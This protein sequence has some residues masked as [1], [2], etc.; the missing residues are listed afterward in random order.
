MDIFLAS[1]SRQQF[2]HRLRSK[3]TKNGKVI[4]FT[5]Y[6]YF[7]QKLDL[8]KLLDKFQEVVLVPRFIDENYLIQEAISPLFNK[9][10]D[11]HLVANPEYEERYRIIYEFAARNN[12]SIKIITVYDFC[13]R[14]LR[15]VYVPDS[16]YEENPRLG[17]M[18]PKGSFQQISKSIIDVSLASVLLAA[19][20]PLW[21]LSRIRITQQSPGPIFYK[22]K[23]VGLNY[24]EFECVKFRSMRLDAEAF[25]A[26]FSSKRDKR[27]FGYGAF[28]RATRID[29]LPQLLNIFRGD[30]S[31]VGPRPERKVFVES[32]EELIPHYATRHVVK[33]GI[34]GYAQV[35]YPYGTGAK[36]AR[37]KLMYDLYYIKNW[38]LSLELK[39]VW[40]TIITV[41][42]SGGF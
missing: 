6:D 10:S 16:V 41:L 5:G 15:K 39:I 23:R 24:E 13:E 12:K 27:V 11:I 35:M 38:S 14:E 17:Q 31:L 3:R 19:T 28:M 32:F 4:L 30:V 34:T 22:Q 2:I 18:R 8:R 42:S 26:Q 36:D 29:E 20:S 1:T 25:G 21:L 9:Y 37:H 7:L 33:P 40:K